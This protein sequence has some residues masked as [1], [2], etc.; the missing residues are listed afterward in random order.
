MTRVLPAQVILGALA[1]GLCA[2]NV[3]RPG[4]TALA[5]L[6]VPPIAALASPRSA[7]VAVAA[8]LA[9]SLGWWWGAVRLDALDRTELAA[10]VG[11]AGDLVVVTTADAR[12]GT[13]VQRQMARAVENIAEFFH[14]A[15]G[16]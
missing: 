5:L 8:A 14:F 3:V 7:P 4:G 9:C 1:A 15:A 11:R 16:H 10:D 13:F 12:P 6:A 2:A